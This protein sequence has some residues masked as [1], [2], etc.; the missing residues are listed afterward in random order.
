MDLTKFLDL[1]LNKTIYL[2]RVDK[3]EDPYEGYISS[4][5]KADLV[6][7]YDELQLDHNIS[8]DSRDRLYATHIYGQE[9]LPM[10]AYASCWY[11]GDV[12]SAAM[13]KLYGEHKN[14]IAICSTIYDL[15]VALDEG[16]DENGLMYLQEVEYVN[17]SSIVDARSFLK[18]MFQ[19][20]TSFSHENEFRAL[21]LLNKGLTLLN[22]GLHQPEKKD[23]TNADGINLDIDV[24][25]LINSIYIS[26]TAGANFKSIV[27]KVLELAGFDGLECIQSDLYKLK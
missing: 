12:E 19:K 18:P 20:R 2:R 10:Y 6:N 15:Q 22:S 7:K 1:I 24:K 14:C 9:L 25:Q 21:Y 17:E 5:Y 27:E 4:A 16:D 11:L 23:V 8:Q 26:P 3:F 13:W